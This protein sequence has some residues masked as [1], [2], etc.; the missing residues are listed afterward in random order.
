MFSLAVG[1]TQILLKWVLVVM[2]VGQWLSGT[3][4]NHPPPSDTEVK[5]EQSYTCS[6]ATCLNDMH[7]ENCTSALPLYC[8]ILQ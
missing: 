1:L 5:K 4:A 8:E 6:P 3:K 2:S 7:K